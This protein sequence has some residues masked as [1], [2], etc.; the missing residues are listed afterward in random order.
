MAERVEPDIAADEH[1]T[2]VG[3]LDYYRATLAVKAA[4][5]TDAAAAT[6]SCP[7]SILTISGLVRHMTEVE[8]HWYRRHLAGED[9]PPMYYTDEAPDDDL[10]LFTSAADR[11]PEVAVLAREVE[12]RR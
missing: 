2:L 6:A 9:A 3:F 11:F 12:G 10:V 1:T 5:L 7:P 4:G 8:R